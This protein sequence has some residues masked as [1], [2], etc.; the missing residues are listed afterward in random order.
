M[1]GLGL[2]DDDDVSVLVAVVVK[3]LDDYVDDEVSVSVAE[4]VTVTESVTVTET[5]TVTVT[6]TVIGWMMMIVTCFIND[7]LIG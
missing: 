4:T 6:K 3:I 2:V 1:N 7:N 5:L